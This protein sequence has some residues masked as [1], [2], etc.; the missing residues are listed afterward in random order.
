MWNTVIDW[1]INLLILQGLMGAFDTIYHH[2][3]TEALPHRPGARLELSIHGLRALL[4]GVVFS[5]ISHFEFRGFWSIAI[6]LLILVEIGLT[7]WDFVIEDKTRK[8]PSTERILH[9]ILAINGGAVFGLYAWQLMQWYSLPTALTWLDFG[10]RANLLSLFAAGVALWGVRDSV[11]AIRLHR[12]L[13]KD[14][15]FREITPHKILITGGT[16]FIGETL[17]NKL[18][19]AG[20]TVTVLTRQPLRAAYQFQGRTCCVRTCAELSKAEHFDAVINLAGAP[21]VGPRWSKKRKEILLESRVATTRALAQWTA[22]T[23]CKPKVWIQASAI[24]YYG[25]RPADELL[26]E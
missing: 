16:G 7:L 12:G 3:L 8:L 15:P 22:S 14:N 10:W 5:A 17:V 19:D 11:A 2:E 9:T 21:V 1:A 24:G 6:V 4:Y 18:L 20:H 25:V 26:D 23:S 13:T